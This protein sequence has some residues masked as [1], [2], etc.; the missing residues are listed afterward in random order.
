[1]FFDTHAHYDDE[2]F[3]ADRDE[4]LSSM[5][6]AGISLI[7]NAGCNLETSEAGCKMAERYPFIYFSAGF[8]PH[9]A[10]AMNSDSVQKMRE[11]LKHEKA[12]AV[13]EIGLDYHYDN[14]PRDVQR[15]RFAEQLELAQE[16]GKPVIIHEREAFE[17][18]MNILS[19]FPYVYNRSV[20]HCFS[21][22]W[23]AARRV[24]DLG[25]MLSFTGAI[26]FKNAAA[27]MEV[28]TRAPIDRLMLET[29]APYL[30]PVPFRGK[31]ND[32]RNIPIYAPRLAAARGISVEEL[33]ERT[34]ENGKRFFNIKI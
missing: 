30:A 11:L 4:L 21:G 16:L 28:A 18:A 23:Q 20:F 5:A 26:T 8:H 7:V 32:S 14:S 2:R 19:D 9:D 29:D 15:A 1:M 17:D 13:G 34:M 33:A 25:F 27:S 6:E 10:K 3:D 31:R 24:L 22:D 12:V